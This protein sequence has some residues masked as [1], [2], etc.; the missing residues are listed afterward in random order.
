MK[1]HLLRIDALTD[2][3]AHAD[4]AA[5][6]RALC[7]D[8]PEKLRALVRERRR[9]ML[10]SPVLRRIATVAACLLLTVA[11]FLT[12]SGLLTPTPAPTPSPTP[13]P[14]TPTYPWDAVGEI[15][16]DSL[17]ML[18]YYG[19]LRALADGYAQE[20]LR[21]ERAEVLLDSGQGTNAYGDIDKNTVFTITEVTFFR[22]EVTEEHT[23]LA[24]RVGVGTV[25]VV[26]TYNSLETMITFRSGHRFFT[27]IQNGA[28]TDYIEFSTHKYVDGFRLVKSLDTVQ[29]RLTVT[30]DSEGAVTGIVCTPH[31][32]SSAPVYGPGSAEAAGVRANAV[33]DTYSARTRVSFTALDLEAY[34][35]TP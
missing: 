22:I 20:L 19:A 27:C 18:N 4:E 35:G 26:I 25:D 11:I 8:T 34:F 1:Q 16:I 33:G 13:P 29:Q 28:G 3:L 23:Y 24:E 6:N 2:Q 15:V 31:T 30:L 32:I 12:A 5:L 17:D 10:H 14:V 21:H 9:R 7:T